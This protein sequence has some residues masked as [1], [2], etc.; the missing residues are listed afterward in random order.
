MH[1]ILHA[2]TLLV[3]FECVATILEPYLISSQFLLY[4][5]IRNKAKIVSKLNVFLLKEAI[6]V[7]SSIFW[8]F[9]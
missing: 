6:C 2:L 4:Y 1:I 8:K 7:Y 5:I 3:V 9:G